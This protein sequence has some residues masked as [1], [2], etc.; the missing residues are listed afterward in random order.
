MIPCRDSISSAVSIGAPWPNNRKMGLQGRSLPLRQSTGEGQ[1]GLFG[2][3]ECHVEVLN[4][5]ARAAFYKVVYGARDYHRAFAVCAGF[6]VA[7]IGV[8]HHHNPRVV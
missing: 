8:R 6:E 4:C 5:L 2:P 3:A 1:P 7:E